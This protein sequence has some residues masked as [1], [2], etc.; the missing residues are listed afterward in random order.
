MATNFANSRLVT[1]PGSNRLLGDIDDVSELVRP[2]WGAGADA[3]AGCHYK[4]QMRSSR[5]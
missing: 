1:R 5:S 2:V 3:D 4:R